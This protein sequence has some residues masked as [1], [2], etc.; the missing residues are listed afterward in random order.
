MVKR[1][2]ERTARTWSPAARALVLTAAVL[3]GTLDDR[4]VGKVSDGRQMIRTAVAIAET[5]EIGQAR[6]ATRTVARPEGDAVS[7]YGMG[8]SFA[9]LPAALLAP[10]AER[11]FGPGASNSLFLIAPLGLVLLAAWS[12]GLA[13]QLLGASPRGRA[14]SVLLTALASPLGS[15]AGL[16]FAEPLLA[17]SLSVAFSASLAATRG[18][19]ARRLRWACAAGFAAGAAVLTKSLFVAVAP[20]ALL[21]L[22]ASGEDPRRSRRIAHAAGGAALPLGLWLVFE[23]VRFGRPFASYGDEGFTHALLAGAFQLL[24]GPTK[25]LLLFFPALAVA[26]AGLVRALSR[27]GASDR[28]AAL[29]VALP[30]AA[31][32][33][34][35]AAWWAWHGM[36]GWGPRFLVP[37]IPLLA[38]VAGVA[39]GSWPTWAR[40]ALLGASAALNL[41]PLLVS[42]AIV[43]GFLTNCRPAVVTEEAARAFPS[44][45][46]QRTEAGPAV[47]ALYV[48]A[49]EPLASPFLVYPWLRLASS[50]GADDVARRLASPPWLAAR[51]ELGPAL[52]PLPPEVARALAPE[53]RLG[54][55]GRS[56]FAPSRADGESRVWAEALADQVVRAQQTERLD[57]ALRLAEKLAALAPGEE[58]DALLLET[59]RLLGRVET[60]ERFVGELPQ[61]RRGAPKLGVV[62]ALFAKDRGD[63]TT[64]RR[65]LGQVAPYFPGAPLAALD[66]A[67]SPL[68]IWPRDLASM[69]TEPEDQVALGLPGVGP[70]SR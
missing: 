58:S 10:S 21:P 9:Q 17:A 47:R 50:G 43:D 12:S 11:A 40:R 30:F 2:P 31:P 8:M 41:P 38:A 55:F 7:R 15:Y 34:T 45:I 70:P 57:R 65:I 52:S 25:G 13:A 66:V 1:T 61:D 46:V 3:A 64:A 33:A 39:L 44:F 23:I 5:F 56:L 24:F 29:G 27:G 49:D 37:A 19:S 32:L 54:F 59:Y 16:D 68:A 42:P 62:L 60:A 28:L 20:L 35:S 63:E 69:T 22:L 51:P 18:E 6:G 26:A 67:A 4:H 36:G 48:L 53:P 14:A